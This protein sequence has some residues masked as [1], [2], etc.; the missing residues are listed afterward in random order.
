MRAHQDR[1]L[2]R[3]MRGF[4]GIEPIAQAEQHRA[5]RLIRSGPICSPISLSHALVV[6]RVLSKTLDRGGDSSS[7]A[8]GGYDAAQ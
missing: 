1:Q 8:A 5:Q 3:E 7:Y 2:R 4:I 6:C